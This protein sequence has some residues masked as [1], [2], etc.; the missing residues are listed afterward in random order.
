M[1]V[2]SLLF[3]RSEAGGERGRRK[4]GLA[5]IRALQYLVGLECLLMTF[6]ETGIPDLAFCDCEDR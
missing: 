4:G 2:G 3:S 5:D 6:A 1:E